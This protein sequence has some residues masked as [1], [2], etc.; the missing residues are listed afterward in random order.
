MRSIA[1]IILMVI[2]GVLS[3]HPFDDRAT[4]TTDVTIESND[5]LRVEVIYRYEG[6]YAAY[7]EVNFL[8]DA[9]KDG[10]ITKKECEARF[11]VLAID[12]G[13]A[14]NIS[15]R[16]QKYSLIPKFDEWDARDWKDPDRMAT[17]DQGMAA[18]DL[19]LVYFFVFELRLSDPLPRGMHKCSLTINS[20]R[21]TIDTPEESLRVFDDRGEYTIAVRGSVWDRTENNRHRVRFFWEVSESAS[22]IPPEVRPDNPD[23]NPPPTKTTDTD[24]SRPTSDKI[25]D[26]QPTEDAEPSIDDRILG[27]FQTLEGGDGTPLWWALVIV[28]GSMFGFGMW[29]A[30]QPGH[31]KT[32]V[33]SYLIGTHG[34]ASDAIFLGIV[35]TLAHTSGVYLLLG[36]AWVFNEFWPGTFD[37]PEQQLAEWITFAVGLT[38]LFM[39]MGLVMKHATQGAHKHDLF[40]RHVHD[41]DHHHDHSHDHDHHHHD[42]HTHELRD[43]DMVEA[44]AHE[45]HD[46]AHDHHDHSHDHGHGHHH[47]ELDPKKMTRWEILRLGMLGGIVPCPSAF[48]IALIAFQQGLYFSGLIMVTFFSLGLA[49]V[50]AAIGLTLV[51]TKGYMRKKSGQRSK[52]AMML[53]RRLPV[54]GASVIMLI[55]CVMTM[56]AL[57]RLGLIDT[58]TFIV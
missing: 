36:G 45:E 42:D 47:D 11:K 38:I 24:T 12:I 40:G 8:L 32:L 51:K 53:E 46:H 20:E 27:A 23:S 18:R 43:S 52:F 4:M 7:N 33:A 31:G 49:V 2:G 26:R 37:N 55:G 16:G 30:I 19:R 9:D 6:A 14:W 58:A 28:L 35:V 57:I 3:A 5:L 22:A 34:T 25:Y 17:D 10:I 44:V 50:L 21:V 1:L 48:V 54:F 41:D 39:G 56:F 29:H 13:S 15:V